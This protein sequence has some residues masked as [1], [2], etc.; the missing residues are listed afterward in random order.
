MIRHL[1]VGALLLGL[2]GCPGSPSQPPPPPV[3]AATLE[4]QAEAGTRLRPR[5]VRGEEVRL[6]LGWRDTARGEDC[7]FLPAADGALRC[8]PGDFSTEYFVDDLCTVPALVF[9]GRD[10]CA[11]PTTAG[12]VKAGGGCDVRWEVRAL[13]APLETVHY[14]SGST[15]YATPPPGGSAYRMG[16]ALEPSA[17]V[18][19][20]R[21][22]SPGTASLSTSRLVA[23]DG[24]TGE[25]QLAD[26]LEGWLCVT[27]PL[28]GDW[29]CVPSGIAFGRTQAFGDL[30]CTAPAFYPP[31]CPGESH[32][33][34]STPDGF[35]FRRAGALA[36]AYQS[37]AGVC[38]PVDADPGAAQL[39]GPPLAPERFAAGEEEAVG[40]RL[41]LDVVRYPGLPLPARGLFPRDGQGACTPHYAADGVLRCL[42]FAPG[43]TAVLP[44]GLRAAGGTYADP[45]CTVPLF[46]ASTPA[47]GRPDT[48]GTC[49]RRA[50]AYRPGPPHV[51]T[52]YS[53]FPGCAVYQ[54]DPGDLVRLG[55]EIPPGSFVPMV[56]E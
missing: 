12:L 22:A 32:V 10:A 16:P 46:P 20:H 38:A 43:A 35:A 27:S 6:F 37:S 56:L 1:A 55:E 21:V 24:A 44:L 40:A 17:F 31:A 50:R 39:L 19:A 26:A 9:L 29:R 25:H 8:L 14:L 52:V 3:V 33:L 45:E 30:E 18:A 7:R 42:P 49:P 41:Q 11:P 34:G 13:G 5:F 51:G 23:D 48:A 54:G 4:N 47:I 2:S 36:P 28:L 15:C 53:S